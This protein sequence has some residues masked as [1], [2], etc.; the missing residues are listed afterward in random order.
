MTK[1]DLRT[2]AL[3]RRDALDPVLREHAG[4]VIA[5]RGLPVT[6]PA[7]AVVSGFW[8]IRSEIDPR[9]LMRTLKDRG[10]RLVLPVIGPRD[11]PLM[12]KAW[13]RDQDLLKGPMGIMQPQPDADALD[14]DILLV[15]LA[16]FDR[17]GQRIGYGAGLYDRTL[18]GLR[19]RKTIVA[20]GIAFAAQEIA[21]VPATSHDAPLDFV[22]TETETINCRSV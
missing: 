8:P 22:L 1:S 7:E 20:I 13:L 6:M 18:S 14:P 10:A 12:F 3:A 16:A 19:A 5:A 15:P 2:E 9:P 4:R 21:R 17:A 11:A